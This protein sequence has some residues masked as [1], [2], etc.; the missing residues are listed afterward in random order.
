MTPDQYWLAPLVLLAA[1]ALDLAVG[2]LPPW[3]ALADCPDRLISGLCGWLAR[4]LDRP[5]RGLA[6]LRWRGAIVSLSLLAIGGVAGWAAQAI[7]VP[8]TGVTAATFLLVLPVLRPRRALDALRGGGTR[9]TAT[10]WTV[11]VENTLGGV[12]W[13]SILGAPGL[14]AAA[15]VFAAARALADGGSDKNAFGF[16]PSRLADVL[17]LFPSLLAWLLA[18]AAAIFV[19]G[20]NPGAALS[21][22]LSGWYRPGFRQTEVFLA[23]LGVAGVARGRWLVSLILLLMMAGL[24][25]LSLALHG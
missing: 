20:A 10:G 4:K 7:L 13:F 16:I 12:F 11:L 25:G 9:P 14:Y 6:A 3:R 23:A 8:L 19:P 21:A 5:A 1:L 22:G 17:A 24:A 2:A 15:A 18:A